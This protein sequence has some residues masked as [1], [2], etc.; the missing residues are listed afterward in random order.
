[1]EKK[2][3]CELFDKFGKIDD[4]IVS[5]E[6]DFDNECC[7]MSLRH[8]DKAKLFDR[9]LYNISYSFSGDKYSLHSQDEYFEKI[10][11]SNEYN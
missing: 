8:G 7:I 10:S 11:I 2:V 1:M 3:T 9:Y 4:D 6:S 5:I